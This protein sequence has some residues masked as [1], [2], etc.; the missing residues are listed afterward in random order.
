ME[1]MLTICYFY[2]IF[3]LEFCNTNPTLLFLQNFFSFL[4]QNTF[5]HVFNRLTRCSHWSILSIINLRYHSYKHSSK[6][7]I[8]QTIYM[9]KEGVV[10]VVSKGLVFLD[11]W[12]NPFWN[13]LLVS[14]VRL[15]QLQNIFLTQWASKLY[16]VISKF[17]DSL[18]NV[19]PISAYINSSFH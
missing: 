2:F 18:T 12:S 17:D 14:F 5:E 9:W 7:I 6:I 13:L 16:C 15:F 8:I 3:Y 19:A 1:R 4:V 11:S 10:V